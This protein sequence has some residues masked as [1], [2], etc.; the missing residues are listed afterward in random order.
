ML[1]PA[2]CCCEEDDEEGGEELSLEGV[3]LEEDKDFVEGAVVEKSDF[4]LGITAVGGV[5]NG[6][7][8]TISLSFSLC[9]LC[10]HATLSL[11]SEPFFQIFLPPFLVLVFLSS[12]SLEVLWASFGLLLVSFE[13]FCGQPR[14]QKPRAVT[15][16]PG[17]TLP[18]SVGVYFFLWDSLLVKHN[19]LQNLS[20]YRIVPL[21]FYSF[22]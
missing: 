19:Q 13:L 21:T 5:D 20:Y 9:V 15:P 16:R 18:V 4:D 17:A 12:V 3:L 2:S 8:N 6:C 14:R 10:P 22:W 7:K 1:A 11:L